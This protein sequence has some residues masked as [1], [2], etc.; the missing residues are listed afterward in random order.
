MKVFAMKQI[1]KADIHAKNRL[2]N[3]KTERDILTKTYG[4]PW[5]ISLH[6]SFQDESFL[7][8]VMEVNI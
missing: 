7:Y 3:I 8:L 1:D 6:F 2:N 5:L 4:I